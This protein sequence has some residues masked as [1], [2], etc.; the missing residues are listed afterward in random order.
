MTPIQR[1]TKARTRLLLD[2]P[3]FGALSMRLDIQPKPGVETFSTDGTHLFFE[4]SYVETLP[5][6]QLAGILAHEV[7]HCALLHPY[8]RGHRDHGKW[9]EACDYA[10]NGE[11]KTANFELPS[12]VLFDAQYNG[13]SAEQIYTKRE[14]DNKPP[15]PSGSG[16]GTQ[17]SPQGQQTPQQGANGQQPGS[18]KPLST[19][20][21]EDAPPQPAPQAD[22]TPSNQ[23]MTAEDWKIASEQATAVSKAAGSEPGSAARAAKAAR[24]STEDWRATLREFVEHTQPSDYSWGSPN[25]R[26]IADGLYLPG[27]VRENLGTIAVAIDTSGSISQAVLDCFAAELTA[28]AQE[29]RPELLKVIYCDTRVR[30]TEEFTADDAEIKLSAHGGGGTLFQP[31]FHYLA[32][33]EEPPV[34]LLYFT[35]LKCSDSPIEPDY[36]VLWVTGI[37]TTKVAPFGRTT[38]IDLYA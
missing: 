36:P 37:D 27:I 1:I 17:Q 24:Q 9:N 29:A 7:M 3:W 13:L 21:V 22:S 4:P 15:D 26:H 5:E 35:D 34:C 23:P 19:G 2:S 30:H 10:I 33:Q 38:K 11:L 6:S 14:R 18:G 32:K 12:D 28:I 16:R 8:R 20:T 31:V 25:R